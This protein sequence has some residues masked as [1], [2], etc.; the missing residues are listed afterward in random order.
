M[1]YIFPQLKDLGYSDISNYYGISSLEE[2]KEY[3]SYD[4]VVKKCC[5]KINT[6]MTK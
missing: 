2:A 1:R 6:F 5:K 3:S 4:E